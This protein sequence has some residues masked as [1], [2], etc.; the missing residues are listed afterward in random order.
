MAKRLQN[1]PDSLASNGLERRLH[2]FKVLLYDARHH[3][4]FAMRG[5]YS[6]HN[7]EV[8]EHEHTEIFVL[9]NFP[10]PF[11]VWQGSTSRNTSHSRTSR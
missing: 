10:T 11:L 9:Q 8:V 3:S 7:P 4:Y 5:R 6:Y 2:A 1:L